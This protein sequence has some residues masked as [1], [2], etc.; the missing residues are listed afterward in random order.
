MSTTSLKRTPSLMFSYENIY[1]NVFFHCIISHKH[2]FADVLENRC[3]YKFRKIHRKT[4]VLESL[5]DKVAGLQTSNLQTFKTSC[6]PVNFTKFLWKSFSPDD[7]FWF[8]LNLLVLRLR[9]LFQN[10]SVLVSR[11]K[12][13]DLRQLGPVRKKIK[14][15]PG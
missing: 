5:F 4:L 2:P 15:F 8:Q 6:F 1:E 14:K 3:S 13:C 12:C 7:C 10:R 9:N 11:W